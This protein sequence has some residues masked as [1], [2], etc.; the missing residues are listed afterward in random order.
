LRT[1]FAD[2]IEK[3]INPQDLSAKI[4]KTEKYHKP[5][6]IQSGTTH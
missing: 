6:K 4:K 3:Q 1:H 5:L 2:K